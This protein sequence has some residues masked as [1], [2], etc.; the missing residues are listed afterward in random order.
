MRAVLSAGSNMGDA[1][2]HLR[3][4]V[5]EFA[6]ETVAALAIDESAKHRSSV[7]LKA[8]RSGNGFKLTGQKQFVTHGH[9][10]DLLIVLKRPHV[11]PTKNR[12]P[13]KIRARET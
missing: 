7:G 8:E 1:R 6:G 9:V 4:V 11:P 3:S 2:A 5:D 10:A 13:A 12:I